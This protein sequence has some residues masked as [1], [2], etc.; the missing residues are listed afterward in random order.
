MCKAM[1]V[2]K[3]EIEKEKE[4]L[5]GKVIMKRYGSKHFGSSFG[6]FM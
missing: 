3:K 1:S 2:C 5:E 6:R 4:E